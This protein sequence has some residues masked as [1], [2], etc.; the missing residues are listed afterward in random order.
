LCFEKLGDF[1]SV[2]MFYRAHQHSSRWCSL[3]TYRTCDTHKA[4]AVSRIM[5]NTRLKE[6]QEKGFNQETHRQ[7]CIKLL[8]L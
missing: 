4:Y 5:M 1:H 8:L 6:E 7:R 3:L 2:Q